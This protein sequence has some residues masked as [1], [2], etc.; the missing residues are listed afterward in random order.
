MS[1]NPEFLL[2]QCATAAVPFLEIICLVKW[3]VEILLETHV[4]VVALR[5]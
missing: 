4:E 5:D 1:Q 2:R 3:G